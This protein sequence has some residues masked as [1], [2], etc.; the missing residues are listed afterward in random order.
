MFTFPTVEHFRRQSLL[1]SNLLVGVT[2]RFEVR[3]RL[4]NDTRP[5]ENRHHLQALRITS[6]Y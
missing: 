2:P 3:R 1:N 6:T 5:R 4:R